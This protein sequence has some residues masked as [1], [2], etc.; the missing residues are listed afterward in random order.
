MEEHQSRKDEFLELANDILSSLSATAKE[1]G[2]EDDVV[3]IAMCGTYD[4]E[5]EKVHA[6][7]DYIAP[8]TNVLINGLEFL[9][10]MICD[11]IANTPQPGTIDWWLD[12]MN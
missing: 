7:Y 8:D 11:E 2:L 5:E 4:E 10:A 9:D 6:I 1:M 3:F 12:R